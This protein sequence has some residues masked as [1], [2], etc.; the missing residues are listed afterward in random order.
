MG[1]GPC[2]VYTFQEFNRELLKA[3]AETG[4]A[5]FTQIEQE[6]NNP[7]NKKTAN[8]KLPLF[9]P[10]EVTSFIYERICNLF[11][12]KAHEGEV[13]IYST[14]TLKEYIAALYLWL[15]R[16]FDYLYLE[17]TAPDSPP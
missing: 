12:G 15:I 3:F 8:K 2:Q 9:D 4:N 10:R 16:R 11:E 17:E 7:E 5:R 14:I 13:R 6:F 1:L